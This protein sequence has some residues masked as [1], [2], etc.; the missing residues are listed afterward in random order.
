MNQKTVAQQTAGLGLV[1]P[2]QPLFLPLTDPAEDDDY[3][4]NPR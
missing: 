1:P 2:P 3:D 4:R